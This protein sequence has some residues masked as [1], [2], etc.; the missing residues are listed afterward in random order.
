M[1]KKVSKEILCEAFA[2]PLRLK[3]QVPDLSLFSSRLSPCAWAHCVFTALTFN[4]KGLDVFRKGRGGRP[5][6]HEG[7]GNGLDI[8]AGQKKFPPA[9]EKCAKIVV[10]FPAL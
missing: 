9:F 4:K 2:S 7:K 1:K 3:G 5:S 10:R 6:A 8:E